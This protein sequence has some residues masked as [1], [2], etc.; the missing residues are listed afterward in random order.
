MDGRFRSTQDGFRE[1]EGCQK[2]GNIKA[3]CTPLKVDFGLFNT[4]MRKM[5]DL[6][7]LVENVIIMVKYAIKCTELIY[8][9]K[10]Y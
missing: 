1:I 10:V 9:Y 5:G 8:S 6:S 3:Q 4:V 2:N 7:Y